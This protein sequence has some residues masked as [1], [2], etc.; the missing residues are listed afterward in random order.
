MNA[1]TTPMMTS[2]AA[3]PL[4]Q[5]LK[6]LNLYGLL[7]RAGQIAGEPWLAQ[8]LEIEETERHK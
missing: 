4:E 1:Q 8:V 5:R 7:A 2:P 6:R 3:E